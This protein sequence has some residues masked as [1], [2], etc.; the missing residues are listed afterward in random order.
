MSMSKRVIVVGSGAAGMAAATAL[1]E[2]GAIVTVLEKDPFV[3]GRWATMHTTSFATAG[4]EWTFPIEHGI[5]GFWRQYRN[6]RALM[7]RHGLHRHMVSSGRQELALCLDGD[8]PR[9][10]DVGDS[11]R[12]SPLPDPFAFAGLLGD[13]EFLR[14]CLRANPLKMMQMA[15]DMGHVFAFDPRK[16]IPDYD[17]FTAAELT[18]GWPPFLQEFF[19]A[20]VH[21]AFFLQV[22]QVG[23]GAFMTSLQH[24]TVCDKRDIGFDY[25]GDTTQ[26]CIFDP[27]IDVVESRGGRV[28]TRNRVEQ[29][30]VE[31]GHVVAVEAA[32]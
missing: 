24:Y 28:L 13:R 1:A 18:R 17:R 26:H 20:L 32:A 30:H 19:Q 15:R 27:L 5:H 23:L 6:L 9:F 8:R 29:V 12:N 31:G 21:M 2:A 22:E 4:R 3:G 16:D 14:L 25:L 7:K 10:L 11:V